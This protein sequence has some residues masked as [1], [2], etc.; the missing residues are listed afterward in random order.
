L[1]SQFD[2]LLSPSLYF[3]LSST[4][5]GFSTPA[6][7]DLRL[8]LPVRPPRLSL[9][10]HLKLTGN[11]ETVLRYGNS[12]HT[13]SPGPLCAI[14]SATPG[15]RHHV[16][17]A[18]SRGYQPSDDLFWSLRNRIYHTGGERKSSAFR[19]AGYLAELWKQTGY[20]RC[21]YTPST[22]VMLDGQR[23]AL[24]LLQ[25]S[26]VKT[27]PQVS[28][29][30][31]VSITSK[32][33]TSPPSSRC[34]DY[35]KSRHNRSQRPIPISFVDRQV[36][37]VWCWTHHLSS[38]HVGTLALRF[39]PRSETCKSPCPA[40]LQHQEYSHIPP[41]SSN[42]EFL[43]TSSSNFG[44]ITLLRIPAHFTG[45]LILGSTATKQPLAAPRR[46][47]ICG[48]CIRKTIEDHETPFR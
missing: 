14:S 16:Q 17:N 13:V 39:S 44:G 2:P 34:I 27:S 21:R 33:L 5:S 9:Q 38:Q 7:P 30:T 35:C 36:W 48:Q 20:C 41:Y 24:G 46:L 31:K 15:R 12:W 10:R 8:G 45:G 32:L 11:H 37:S 6:R 40:S 47:C 22:T 23:A 4:H 26:L 3:R 18:Y 19:Y 29:S 28:S 25:R 1:R 43:S 42:A